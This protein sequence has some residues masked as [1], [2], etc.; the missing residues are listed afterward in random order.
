[1][2]IQPLV[3]LDD[4]TSDCARRIDT[5]PCRNGKLLLIPVS[6]NVFIELRLKLELL[7]GVISDDLDVLLDIQDRRI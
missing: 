1:M 5:L 3:D 6:T 7:F 4:V 2:L